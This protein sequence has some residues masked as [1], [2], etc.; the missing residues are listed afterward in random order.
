LVF[1]R[2]KTGKPKKLQDYV[3][4]NYAGDFDQRKSTMDYVFTVAECVIN[5]NAVLQ[6]MVALSMIEAEYI[7]AV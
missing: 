1:Q 6:N 3:D 2:L 5:W 7:F 4:A